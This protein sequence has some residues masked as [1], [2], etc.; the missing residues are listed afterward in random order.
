M[1]K[2]IK[3]NKKPRKK[4]LIIDGQNWAHRAFHAQGNLT[5]NG[6]K[7]GLI[8]GF[9]NMLQSTL[10]RF[11]TP[12][13]VYVCFDHG[14]NQHRL[15]ILPDYKNRPKKLDFDRESFE[16]QINAVRKILYYMGITCLYNKMTEADDYIAQL[17]ADNEN[18]YNVVICSGDKDFRQLVSKRVTI[19]DEK[20]GRITPLN[21][22]KLFGIQPSQY[23]DF[24]M[25]MGDASDH[26]PG[27]TG[28]GEKTAI[29]M[30]LE[31]GSM[32]NFNDNCKLDTLKL[33]QSKDI[34][35]R[36][37][38]LID[39]RYFLEKHGPQE[40]HFYKDKK[41]PKFNS[42]KYVKMCVKYGI[43][44]FRTEEFIQSFQHSLGR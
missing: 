16:E 8:Y 15:D 5:F 23:A 42:E 39:L 2:K 3:E 32:K 14:R 38:T 36:N 1:A 20:Y 19:F 43:K 7:M 37:R 31:W 30:L 27:I 17:V 34:Y 10:T 41:K 25:M 28:V 12:K 44:K 11:P 22:E 26:I 24:L 13:A 4:V 9:I 6:K 29:K 18:K 40:L 21:F 35:E 33:R